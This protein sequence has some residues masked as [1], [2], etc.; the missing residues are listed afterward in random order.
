MLSNTVLALHDH[1]GGASQAKCEGEVRLGRYLERVVDLGK[2][3]VVAKGNGL[4][5][6][7]LIAGYKEISPAKYDWEKLEAYGIGW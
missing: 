1:A 7:W 3:R 4:S 5:E 6:A 2:F